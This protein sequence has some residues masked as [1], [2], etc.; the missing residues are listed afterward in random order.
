MVYG[1]G[2]S[3]DARNRPTPGVGQRKDL[4]GRGR[5]A[6]ELGTVLVLQAE[7]TPEASAADF[8]QG[9]DERHD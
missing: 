6:D 4:N 1:S 8:A 5:E 9:D 2:I 7:Q 3:R